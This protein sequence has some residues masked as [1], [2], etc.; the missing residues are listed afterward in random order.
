M[1]NLEVV[2]PEAV[3]PVPARHS[4]ADD[5]KKSQRK[6]SFNDIE[7]LDRPGSPGDVEKDHVNY[8]KV[9]SE[10][11]KYVGDGRLDI[12]PEENTRLRRMIDR[13]VLVVMITT[14]FL[15][16]IDK[17]TM[18]FASIMG[19]IKDTGLHGQQVRLRSILPTISSKPNKAAKNSIV[20][21]QRVSTSRFSS[22]N[23]LRTG[24]SLECPLPST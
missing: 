6:K 4:H 3:L 19:T 22:L 8:D 23:I 16:A 10:L 2:D 1:S 7:H 20:G 17:G 13:R 11:A 18:S 24:T 14:Y 21:S 15:Q 12:P 5:D 9:D